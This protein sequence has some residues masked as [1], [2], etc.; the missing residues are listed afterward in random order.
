[1]SLWGD[2]TPKKDP[3][4]VI[5]NPTP[6]PAPTVNVNAQTEAMA[7][8]A[9]TEAAKLLPPAPVPPPIV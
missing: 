3:E 8:A 9:L 7:P 5:T 4:P 2:L 1:M 6:A